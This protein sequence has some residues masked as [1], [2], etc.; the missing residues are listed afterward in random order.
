MLSLTIANV[1]QLKS[2]FIHT[3]TFPPMPDAPDGKP[4]L[5]FVTDIASFSGPCV[6]VLGML[7]MGATLGR[8]SVKSLPKG[9][10]KSVVLMAGLKLVMG[11]IFP[12]LAG[13]Q[14]N[15]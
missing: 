9:F 6:P 12:P 11:K 7:L 14:V 10:W 1:S 8:L 5:D 2:L 13:E 15:K 4:L 3:L